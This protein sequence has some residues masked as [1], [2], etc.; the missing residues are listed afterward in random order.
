MRLERWPVKAKIKILEVII[1]L[2]AGNLL[3]FADHSGKFVMTPPNVS[4]GEL[5]S[6]LQLSVSTLISIV[7]GQNMTTKM[8]VT[9]YHIL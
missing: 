3:I 2:L 4:P 5:C 6:I 8:M 9:V 1:K 7:S